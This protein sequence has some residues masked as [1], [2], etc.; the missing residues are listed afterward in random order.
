MMGYQM[1]ILRRY[2]RST[3]LVWRATVITALAVCLVGGLLPF[4]PR[5]LQF[6]I[7]D[8]SALSLGLEAA[9][10]DGPCG[11]D[12]TYREIRT[13]GDGD[14]GELEL[15]AL[16]PPYGQDLSPVGSTDEWAVSLCIAEDGSWTTAPGGTPMVQ[17]RQES[18][19][20][21]SAL[22]ADALN[23]NFGSPDVSTLP[24]IEGELEQ[25]RPF[26]VGLETWIEVSEGS[27]ERDA[28]TPS[29]SEGVSVGVVTTPIAVVWSFGSISGR[30]ANRGGMPE[31]TSGSVMTEAA[32][33]GFTPTEYAAEE[34]ELSIQVEYRITAT[35]SMSGAS[36]SATVL[37]DAFTKS[38][39]VDEVQVFGVDPAGAASL[40][41]A[42]REYNE[43]CGWSPGTWGRCARDAVETAVDFVAGGLVL[44]WDLARGCG[45]AVVD[46]FDEVIGIATTAWDAVRDPVG[47]IEEQ[48]E[49]LTTAL[50]EIKEDLGGAAL[51]LL[52]DALEWDLLE[53]DP[54]AWIGK[55]GCG[56]LIEV[57][58]GSI[59]TKFTKWLD[60]L[61][62]D[63]RTKRNSD[64][65]TT[66]DVD[67]DTDIDTTHPSCRVNNSFPTGTQ[68]LM[69]DGSRK[70]INLISVGDMVMAYNTDA[71][72]WSPR[73][74]LDQWS[75]L[76]TGEMATL[77]LIDGSEVSATDHHLFWVNDLG[78]WVE[79]EDL[80]PGDLLLTPGGVT[81][82][83][84][85]DL[86]DTDGT[87]VWELTVDIDHTFTVHTGTADVLV[88]NE[89]LTPCQIRAQRVEELAADPATGALDAKTRREATV[90]LDL[91]EAGFLEGPITR[92]PSGA[93]EFIDADGQAWDVKAFN[94][95]FANG[96]DR[97]TA[98]AAIQSEISLGENVILDTANL[99]LAHQ[100]ELR[101]AIQEAGLSDNV[102]WSVVDEN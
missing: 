1:A 38:R 6:A 40:P 50:D 84:E 45:Q 35:G 15:E 77:T 86:W 75:H 49:T 37:S 27:W 18:V 69:A 22:I 26:Y 57:L 10:A 76:D 83:A 68:V 39:R 80:A 94:S 5:A 64:S 93:A 61:I 78:E 25:G 21:E 59:A 56:I 4:V 8:R 52:K 12:S 58:S 99:S 34:A 101:R 53:S 24:V 3:S 65:D 81:T 31:D 46:K 72:V 20:A 66:N 88:H 89:D 98:L 41:P 16:V 13:N 62:A 82:L 51:Q 90:G 14:S 102:L 70:A 67:D 43:G 29:P 47:W 87:L 55:V 7:E 23:H 74:V 30:C 92:D 33:C 63:H 11:T 85:V 91:E 60:D 100:A 54:V 73:M 36:Q 71:A 42:E 44:L 19:A 17:V 48:V 28:S 2:Q 9:Y 32:P 96:Y 95:N 97:D 79:A